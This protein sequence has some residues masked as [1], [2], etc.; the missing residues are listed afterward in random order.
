MRIGIFKVMILAYTGGLP[1]NACTTAAIMKSTKNTT[2]NICAIPTDAAA[3]PPK[4]NTAAINATT[5]KVIAQPNIIF[6]FVNLCIS[7]AINKY[8]VPKKNYGTKK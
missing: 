3:I 1:R 7:N 8:K 4:P 6:P 5:K 2:N